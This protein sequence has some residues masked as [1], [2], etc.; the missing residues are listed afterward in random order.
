MT[1]REY[2]AERTARST[3]PP[4]PNIGDGGF[5]S[6]IVNLH[7]TG[8]GEG[9][10]VF[11]RRPHGRQRRVNQRVTVPPGGTEFGRWHNVPKVTKHVRSVRLTAG[12]SAVRFRFSFRGEAVRTM[13]A[14]APA[15]VGRR[16]GSAGRCVIDQGVED[17]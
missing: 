10:P 11:G 8:S 14:L 9:G 7:P 16:H 13:S 15:G 1:V 5:R 3:G 2:R 4:I 6:P 17:E 12:R